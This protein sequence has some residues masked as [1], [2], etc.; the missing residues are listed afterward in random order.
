MFI[1]PPLMFTAACRM[2]HSPAI[3]ELEEATDIATSH[4]KSPDAPGAPSSRSVVVA[5]RTGHEAAPQGNERE[6]A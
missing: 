1:G 3:D 2:F 6:P 4:V 5:L